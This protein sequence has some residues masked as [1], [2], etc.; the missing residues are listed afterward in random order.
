M[1]PK[2]IRAMCVMV[3]CLFELIG[4]ALYM[5]LCALLYS[6]GDK[7]PFFGVALLDVCICLVIVVLISTGYVD[8]PYEKPD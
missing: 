7:Y 5:K 6:K 1:Y 8:A 3:G 2:N 4:G